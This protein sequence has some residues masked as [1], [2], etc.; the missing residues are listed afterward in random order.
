MRVLQDCRSPLAFA[1]PAPPPPPLSDNVIPQHRHVFF[2][3][4]LEGFGG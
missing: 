4:V 3:S 2:L 1:L